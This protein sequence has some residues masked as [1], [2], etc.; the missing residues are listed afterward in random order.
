M[1]LVYAFCGRSAPKDDGMR[2]HVVLPDDLIQ[3]LDRRAG[4]RGRSRL[5]ESVVREWL[6][7]EDL[8]SALEEFRAAFA[9]DPN[10]DCADPV[11][12]VRAIR[13]EWD[14][15]VLRLWDD[16]DESSP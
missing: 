2:A 9:E 3:E 14:Q 1:G 10:P 15:R 4:K 12:W 6:R 13:S 16:T 8:R 5:L 7:R 11:G